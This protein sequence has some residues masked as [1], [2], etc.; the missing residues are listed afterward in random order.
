MSYTGLLQDG[1]HFI[2]NNKLDGTSLLS[3]LTIAT[4]DQ[5]DLGQYYCMAQY[6]EPAYIEVIG[7]EL[8]TLSEGSGEEGMK[9]NCFMFLIMTVRSTSLPAVGL[10]QCSHMIVWINHSKISIYY[11][12]NFLKL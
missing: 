12:L 8:I 1:E 10:S 4:V 11:L 2:T 6:E 3:A 7:E 9:F 5:N